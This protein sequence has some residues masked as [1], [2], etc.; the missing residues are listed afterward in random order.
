M[1][2]ASTASDQP[3]LEHLLA[4]CAAG[5]RAALQVVYRAEAGRMIAVAQRILRR[6]TLAEEAVQDAFVLIWRNAAKFDPEKG[7]AMTWIYTVLRNRSLSIL[8]DESRVEPSHNPIGDEVADEAESPEAAVA[9][10]SDAEALRH[11]L[12]R[13][14]PRR[15]N[16]IALAYVHGLSHGELA[17]KLGI[18]LG[19]IK[20][21]MRRSLMTLRECL[22]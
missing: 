13:L 2:Q 1:R 12:E 10:L 18:P 11:C 14:D 22:Q 9:R 8:R 19:T 4:A 15:R 3:T 7:S 16:A 17:G 6:R 5:D 21:W 20:S